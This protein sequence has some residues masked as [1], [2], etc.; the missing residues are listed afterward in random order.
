MNQK[1]ITI[2]CAVVGIYLY[3]NSG[4]VEETGEPKTTPTITTT[5]NSEN[6]IQLP[7]LINN[8]PWG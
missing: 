2:I 4:E 6:K 5:D 8:N 3:S 7:M 1:L